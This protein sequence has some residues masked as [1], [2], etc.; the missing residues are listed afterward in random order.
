MGQGYKSQFDEMQKI[1]MME[2]NIKN[3]ML[4]NLR[5][6]FVPFILLILL[7]VYGGIFIL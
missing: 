2:V 6:F 5:I 4:M 3:E 7:L 1:D